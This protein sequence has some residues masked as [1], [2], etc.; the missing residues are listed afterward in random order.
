[1]PGYRS[2]LPAILFILLL[3]CGKPVPELDNYFDGFDGTI[4]IYDEMS[5]RYIRF[6]ETRAVTRFSP[7]STFKI[8]NALIALE[9]GVIPN[10]GHV[11][12]W[13]SDL[14]PRQAWWSDNPWSTRAKD[15]TLTSAIKYSVVWYFKELAKMIGENRYQQYL[16]GFKYGNL[17]I[18]GGLT[19]FWLVSSLKISAHEQ[20]EFLQNFY[21]NRLPFNPE[22][23]AQIKDAIILEEASGFRL[24]GK[25]GLG[26]IGDRTLGWLVGYIEKGDSV[27]FYALNIE[28]ENYEAVRSGRLEIVKDV[29]RE[30]GVLPGTK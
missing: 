27:Y 19:N 21:H 18:S 25:T 15:H 9:S 12:P 29:F 30:L 26:I 3:S 5:G 24:S 6:N 11:I 10:S 28:S 13:N 8:P 22:N 17:D 23:I 4:V 2:F 16:S 7:C 20:V 1:M 14:Y